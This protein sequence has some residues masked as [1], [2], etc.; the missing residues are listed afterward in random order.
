MRYARDVLFM[1]CSLASLALG[2]CFRNESPTDAMLDMATLGLWNGGGE[3]MGYKHFFTKDTAVPVRQFPI[4]SALVQRGV[5]EIRG[6]VYERAV[7]TLSQA[8]T[9]DP[10]N[11]SAWFYRGYAKEWAIRYRL[12]DAGSPRC[13]SGMTSPIGI[14]CKVD[15]M[16][17]QGQANRGRQAVQA[18]Y[19]Q[20]IKLL[21]QQ[22]LS[23]S[24][25]GSVE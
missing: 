2:G 17:L 23:S 15:E 14:S 6:R 25:T 10:T 24:P 5:D 3:T 9:M 22:R 8:I 21:R 7:K 20:A 11:A 12:M 18:D 16:T 4:T 1:A 19:E 13:K